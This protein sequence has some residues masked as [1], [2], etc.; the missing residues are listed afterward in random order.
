MSLDYLEKLGKAMKAHKKLLV[1]A[2]A[3]ALADTA[4]AAAC[5]VGAFSV[6]GQDPCLPCASGTFQELTGQTSC[7]QAAPGFFVNIIGASAQTACSVGTFQGISAATSCNLAPPGQFVDASGQV[8]ATSCPVGRYQPNAGSSNCL[9][10][11]PGSFVS[12]VGAVVQ[13]SCNIGTYQDQSASSSCNLASP[14][15]F[16]SVVG[17]A[18]A[19]ACSPGTFQA[20]AGQS[21]CDLSPPGQFVST[22]GQSASLECNAGYYQPN[23]GS[24]S[25][26][27]AE[28]GQFVT[29][30]G[31]SSTTACS[32]GSF[33]ANI[34]STSCNL[35][36]PGSF[37]AALGSATQTSCSIGTYQGAAGSSSCNQAS[38]GFFVGEVGA[39]SATACTPGTFQDL[40]GSSS[41]NLANPGYFVSSA[42]ATTQLAA[43]VGTFVSVSGAVSA[44]AC[45]AGSVSFGA[46]IACR[47]A[48][49]TGPDIVSPDF[50]SD[51]GRGGT[52]QLDA[53]IDLPTLALLN[54]NIRND[55][56][57]VGV[58]DPLTRLTLN[59]INDSSTEGSVSV[60]NFN[61]GQLLDEGESVNI[62]LKFAPARL[63]Y[64]TLGINV[65]TDEGAELGQQGLAF[66]FE[67]KA[68]ADGGNVAASLL[69][70]RPS[71][72]AGDTMVVWLDA[73]NPGNTAGNNNQL[74]LQLPLNT[75]CNWTAMPEKGAVGDANSLN[76]TASDTVDLPARSRVLYRGRCAT[77][78]AVTNPM[79]LS[80][81]ILP[82]TSVSDLF[83]VDNS[84][85]TTVAVV[86]PQ[87]VMSGA[88]LNLSV[89]SKTDFLQ[90]DNLET[91]V[92]ELINNGPGDVVN[93]NLSILTFG[94]SEF[95]ELECS[96]QPGIN[97]GQVRQAG[98]QYRAIDTPINL[99]EGQT[100]QFTLSLRTRTLEG[101]Q[102][103]VIAV[104]SLPPG[105]VSTDFPNDEVIITTTGGIFR[106]SFE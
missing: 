9:A 42:G 25:C 45:P 4:L 34:G 17:A 50:N 22:A 79:A 77:T 91:V 7:D 51:L 78:A 33:Q 39:S 87:P 73:S 69:A 81:N 92:Y 3:I 75:S 31:Q 32:I 29:L 84:T 61:P 30:T 44:Q 16:V 100:K 53:L 70:D 59:T 58:A 21:S 83:S 57:A 52:Y 65:D 102:L 8:T 74:G 56:T 19:I 2:I 47:A 96:D 60:D 10:A 24:V 13:T 95:I 12:S 15:F 14:G 80:T 76:T 6:D 94:A 89:L 41:C 48:P 38:P 98:D 64:I 36:Q 18:S 20:Q 90:P 105:G 11:D 23:E 67:F 99:L 97:C 62:E 1:A 63:G 43:P 27:P 28:P 66:Q 37:V 85:A 86:A 40:A 88:E 71:I 101:Q 49:S 26:L 5:P 35:A 82:D 103:K 93:G 55:A 54:L 72:A 104:A 68:H 46:S 106:N